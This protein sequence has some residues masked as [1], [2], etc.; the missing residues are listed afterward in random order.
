MRV[1]GA[2]ASRVG[3]LRI[4]RWI[5]S[6]VFCFEQTHFPV[7]RYAR[8]FGEVRSTNGR[9]HRNDAWASTP[10]KSAPSAKRLS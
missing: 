6:R 7:I 3:G 9:H 10:S 1:H 5:V 8:V 2:S 4:S